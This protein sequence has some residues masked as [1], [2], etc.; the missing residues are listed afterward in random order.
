YR[1]PTPD[2]FQD[3][4]VPNLERSSSLLVVVTRD[5]LAP[6]EDG[7]PNWVDREIET[8]VGLPGRRRVFV[9]RVD[10]EL[11]GPLPRALRARFPRVDEIDL[12]R[13]RPLRLRA[14]VTARPPRLE[15]LSL[16]AALLDVPTEQMPILMREEQRLRR[17][18]RTRIAIVAAVLALV[19]LGALGY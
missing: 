1:R 6:G 5:A 3:F 13:L 17:A 12:R 11:G 15:L 10:G 19:L 7:K 9:A 14:R 4:I 16:I 8:F 18:A 2:F